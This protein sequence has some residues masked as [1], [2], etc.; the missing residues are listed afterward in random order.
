MAKN[1]KMDKQELKVKRTLQIQRIKLICGSLTN[2]IYQTGLA[3]TKDEISKIRLVYYSSQRY[4]DE[5]DELLDKI[6]EESGKVYNNIA[7]KKIAE[8]AS[9]KEKIN[10]TLDNLISK[11][12]IGIGKLSK[13]NKFLISLIKQLQSI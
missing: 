5:W 9:H 12:T 11:D 2:F 7:E 4:Y 10:F 1:V 3:K 6:Q 8:L 13:I